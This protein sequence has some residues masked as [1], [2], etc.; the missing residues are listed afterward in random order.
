L[1]YVFQQPSNNRKII[2]KMPRLVS[3]GILI[4]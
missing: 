2:G 3:S 4:F 1:T